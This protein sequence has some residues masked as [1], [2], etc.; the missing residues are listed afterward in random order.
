MKFQAFFTIIL[1][2]LNIWA[3][4]NVEVRGTYVKD[5]KNFIYM[6]SDTEKIKIKKSE[7]T[8][9]G[10][11]QILANKETELTLFVPPKSIVHRLEKP[12]T[13]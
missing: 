3:Q 8:K 12:K 6:E 7:L 2:S 1:F 5:N 9:E 13:N 4:G 10:V 11:K